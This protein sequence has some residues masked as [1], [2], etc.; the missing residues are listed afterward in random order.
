MSEMIKQWEEVAALH[1][2]MKAYKEAINEHITDEEEK[3]DLTFHND[4]LRFVKDASASIENLKENLI[5]NK[6]NL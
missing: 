3:F 5:K 4:Y 1:K 2:E 6:F